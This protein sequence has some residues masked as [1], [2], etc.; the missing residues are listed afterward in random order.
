MKSQ[1]KV[2]LFGG[3][4]M[5]AF[6]VGPG[7]LVFSVFVLWPTLDALVVSMQSWTG[8]SPESQ[9]VGLQN[10]ASLIEDRRF[11]QSLANTLYYVVLGG[12]G[13]FAFAFLFASALNSPRLAGKKFYQTL[14]FFPAFI[15]VVGV[16]ILWSRLYSTTDGLI[17]Q[18]LAGFGVEPG[19]EWLSDR[20][21]MN[22]II[23][24]SIWAGVGGQMILI[25]AGMRRIP[26]TYYEAARIDGANEIHLFRH[27]T[28][29]M[30]KD[31]IY[32]A[33]SLW[34]IGSMQVFGLVQA[35]DG[36][37]VTIELETVRTYQ[38]AIAFNAQDNLYMMGR[39]T[40]M[41]IILVIIIVLLVGVARMA[42]GRRELEY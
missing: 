21:A 34:L 35:L 6:M 22:S 37:D 28:L 12:V 36:P 30:L 41:A 26:A 3:Q 17:N 40:A 16:A 29:P 20:N 42:F 4:W 39:G 32:V 25:L 24:S 15:S 11:W 33:L 31:V 2:N 13:H 23:L 18:L 1:G 7:L 5:V 8:F 10:Y 27:V 14:I 38:Y 9:F 19:I